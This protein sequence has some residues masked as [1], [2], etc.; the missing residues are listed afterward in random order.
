M[1]NKEYI[2]NECAIIK[3][4]NDAILDLDVNFLKK[5]SIKGESSNINNNFYIETKH[6]NL[7]FSNKCEI[8][9]NHLKELNNFVVVI[10]SGKNVKKMIGRIVYND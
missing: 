8:D 2:I 5:I 9:I 3:S 1:D 4:K 7:F 10:S 6:V